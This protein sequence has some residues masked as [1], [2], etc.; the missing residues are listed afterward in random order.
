MKTIK[1]LG[2]ALAAVVVSLVAAPTVRAQQYNTGSFTTVV[3]ASTTSNYTSS[4]VFTCTKYEDVSIWVQS[5][6][7]DAG[8]DNTTVSFAKSVDGTTYETTPSVVVTI[9]NTGTTT[10]NTITNINVGAAGYLRLS[11]I[12]NGDT[13]DALTVT[14]TFAVKPQRFGK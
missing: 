10:V 7:A 4:A 11:S 9:A 12:V 1:M 6:I 2:L 5:K 14:N 8:T 13:G 3:A